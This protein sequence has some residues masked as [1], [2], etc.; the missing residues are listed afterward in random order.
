MD[1][2]IEELR[3]LNLD[4]EGLK[5]RK[6]A[7]KKKALEHRDK[8][9]DEKEQEAFRSE[10]E[11]IE[12]EIKEIEKRKAALIARGQN[13]NQGDTNMDNNILHF[14]EGMER[15]DILSTAEYRSAFF[16]SLQGRSLTEDE[17]RSI[18][19]ATAS[20]GAAIPTQTMNTIIGQL[21]E[22]PT[23]L[24]LI[25]LY[26]IPELISLP[27]ENLVNDASWIAEDTDS[28][29]SD[30]T[31][32]N[33]TL[34]AYK[35]IK[36]VKVTAKLKEMAID[37]F[38]SWVIN[39]ITRKMRAA[40][41]KAV[42]GG[43]GANQPKG[44]NSVTW[45]EENSVTVAA[46]GSLSYDDLVD[47][48]ALVGEDYIG[49]AVWVMNRKTKS[50]IMKLKDDQK[51]PL[52]ERAIEDGFVGY[53]LGYPVRLDKNVADNEIY[54]GDWKAA[55]VMNFAKNIEFASSQEAGFMSGATIYRGLALVDGKPTEVPGAMVK[56]KKAS[57]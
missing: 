49:N 12:N 46:S 38:E 6:E 18:T 34:S 54:F 25:T 14:K 4:L 16:K 5:A 21:S 19:S 31:L 27:K 37:A 2:Y 47:A 32:T 35:L 45:D 10:K 50:Q 7:I 15:S 42:I 17:K 30:D 33:I 13:N 53:L 57:A 40:C 44:L 51:R 20:G 28:T 36:T 9:I 3:D 26:N 55:Y 11:Q 39:S 52:F 1:K 29:P 56:V 48:E 22:T 43:T 41:D 24:N 23:V 8:I